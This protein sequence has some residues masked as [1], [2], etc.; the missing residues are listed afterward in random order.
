VAWQE[1]QEVEIDV[2]DE[3]GN[4]SK[5]VQKVPVYTMCVVLNTEYIG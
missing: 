5:E 2:A 3:D 1:Y 4:T